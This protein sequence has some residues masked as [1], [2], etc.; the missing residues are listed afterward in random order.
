[1]ERVAHGPSGGDLIIDSCVADGRMTAEL[2]LRDPLTAQPHEPDV[3]ALMPVCEVHNTSLAT[4][5]ASAD[6]VVEFL[7]KR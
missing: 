5:V 2:F 3:T 1:V 7:K 4:N 6:A